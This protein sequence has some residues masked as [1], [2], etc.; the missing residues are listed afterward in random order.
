MA[1]RRTPARATPADTA[2][3]AGL[4][5]LEAHPLFGRLL[6]RVVLMRAAHLPYPQDGWAWVS[7]R[8]NIYAHPTRL[9]APEE[10][11]FVLAHCL[12][13]LGF[14]HLQ[15]PDA[16]ATAQVRAWNV[17]CD[18]VCAHFLHTLKI[19]RPPAAFGPLDDLPG[20]AEAHWFAQFCAAGIPEAWQ[21]LSPAGAARNT[22]LPVA[23]DPRAGWRIAR[24]DF[25]QLFAA[26]LAESVADAVRNVAG[27][28][29]PGG[30][31][32]PA[33]QARAWFVNSYPLLGALAAQFELVDDPVVCQRLGVAVAAI[34]E[35]SREL[36]VN[37]AA[38]LAPEELRFVLAHELLHVGLRHQDRCQGRDPLLWNVACDFVINGWLVE[39]QVGDFPRRGALYDPTLHG[40]SA[41]AIYDRAVRD[42][43]RFR[44]RATL[45]GMG[46]TD[47]L[48]R[49]PAGWNSLDATSF[50][51]FCRRTLLQGL[52][53]HQEHARGWLPAG[54]IEAIR[55]L[56]HPPIPWEVALARWFEA[57]FAPLEPVRS[58]ARVSRRQ[59]ATPDIPRPKVVPRPDREDARTFGVVLDTSGSMAH[60][61]PAVRVVFC[62]AVPYDQGYMT[63]AGLADRVAVK[64]RGGTVLQPGIDLLETAADFPH[65][66]PILILTDG[67][68]DVVR[69]RRAH[70]F[71]IPEAAQLPFTAKGPI[72]RVS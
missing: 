66:A 15:P 60:D 70:A 19:G 25:P 13:H 34:D 37:P 33:A 67:A 50:D 31:H 58:Y 11:L 54:L 47:M 14:G 57:Y 41:E 35:V 23:R 71:L 3:R 42:I 22:M 12:L 49:T 72:F 24:T 8:G 6:P 16:E 44:K 51:A 38:G 59:A 20:F 9:A 32:T 10:W 65:D 17:A 1:K 39:M 53:Y 64:G 55:A 18:C 68:C 5:L 40:E 26:A 36:Y 43:R 27:A 46:A 69:I 45:A 52:Q 63:L 21:R 48:D 30:T 28:S 61:V 2:F 62:D 29:T 7:A 4:T 56:D